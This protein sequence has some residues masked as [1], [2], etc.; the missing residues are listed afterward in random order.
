MTPRFV[1]RPLRPTETAAIAALH[2]ELFGS[3]TGL[4]VARFGPEFLDSVFYRLNMDNP[5]F[6]CDV[7][8]DGGKLVGFT[9]WTMDRAGVFRHLLRRRPLAALWGTLRAVARRPALVTAVISNLRY[10]GGERL[11]PSVDARGWCLIVAVR[12]ECRTREWEAQSGGRVATSL[13]DVMES[14]MKQA[15]CDGWIGV[16]RADNIAINQF[17]IR[18][19]SILVHKAPAQGMEMVYYRKALTGHE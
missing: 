6:K 19:G 1:V 7:A 11:P 5:A 13:I 14:S 10:L 18:R 3:V 16:V 9:V 12:A 17:L 2:Y 15:H 4:S 8:D